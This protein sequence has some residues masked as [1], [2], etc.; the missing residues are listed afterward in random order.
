MTRKYSSEVAE[1][2]VPS[3]EMPA[4]LTEYRVGLFVP[5]GCENIVPVFFV[6]N[7]VF[8]RRALPAIILNRIKRGV[9][10]TFINVCQKNKSTFCRKFV[11]MA[12]PNPGR[13]APPVIKATL[14]SVGSSS[15]PFILKI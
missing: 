14:F 13:D 10:S 1:S 6:C 12:L 4:L 11:S 3:C 9:T 8:K 2:I 15:S 5:D 7:I